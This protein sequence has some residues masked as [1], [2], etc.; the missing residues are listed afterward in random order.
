M[1]LKRCSVTDSPFVAV[2]T[3]RIRFFSADYS[4]DHLR[5]LRAQYSCQG[6]GGGNLVDQ[7]RSGYE[8]CRTNSKIV[9]SWSD[10]VSYIGVSGTE[11]LAGSLAI[12][13][14]PFSGTSWQV[15]EKWFCNFSIF[16]RLCRMCFGNSTVSLPQ[17]VEI[18]PLSLTSSCQR[19]TVI[20]QCYGTLPYAADDCAP[21][22][23]WNA[24]RPIYVITQRCPCNSLAVTASL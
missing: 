1:A 13:E 17:G 19:L 15:G 11:Q 22:A 23:L 20:T 7:V 6:T 18:R 3:R 4:Q 9:Q 10:G 8:L 14:N 12:R 21:C 16:W 24:S 2:R 5:S